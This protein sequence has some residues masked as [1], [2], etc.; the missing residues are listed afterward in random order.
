MNDVKRLKLLVKSLKEAVSQD[1]S[2]FGPVTTFVNEF[3]VEI[4]DQNLK[5]ETKNALIHYASLISQFFAQYRS[6]GSYIAPEQISKCEQ[7]VQEIQS[8]SS[9]LSK[10]SDEEFLKL[11]PNLQKN[12]SGE[13]PYSINDII[14]LLNRFHKVALN[15]Q[16]RYENRNSLFIKDEYDVQDLLGSLLIVFADDIRTEEYT[17][18]YSGS[19]SRVDFFLPQ[20]ELVIET[21]MTRKGFDEKGIGKQ[22]ND[23]IMRYK[24][25]EK[26]KNLICF[27]YDPTNIIRNPNGV[28]SD[29]SSEEKEFKVITMIRPKA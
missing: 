12:S 23:D 17:P 28:E 5:V 16:Q 6:G 1:K 10:I 8:L 4:E 13:R 21:K 25:I 14:V 22:L 11:F 18:S 7:T 27:I 3:A 29:L 26:C 20:I 15:L 9:R 24:K 19:S 2:F